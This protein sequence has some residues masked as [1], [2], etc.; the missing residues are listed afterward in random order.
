MKTWSKGTQ[1]G[2]V[3]REVM[4]V[5]ESLR[6]YGQHQNDQNLINMAKFL[7]ILIILWLGL[8]LLRTHYVYQEGLKLM[9]ILLPQPLMS[10]LLY[11]LID[12][13]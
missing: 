13:Q 5:T 9:K 1:L 12:Q 11:L 3:G 6:G 7:A 4:Q 8:T 10:W 2:S